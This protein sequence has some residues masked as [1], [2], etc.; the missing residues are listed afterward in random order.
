MIIQLSDW[1]E[2]IVG[3][4]EIARYEQFLLFPQ[5]FQK[6][7]FVDTLKWVSMEE[8][9]N[10]AIKLTFL[11]PAYILDRPYSYRLSHLQCF[12]Y[13]QIAWFKSKYIL[14]PHCL[15]FASNG[16]FGKAWLLID[17][18]VFNSISVISRRLVHL[19]ILSWSGFNHYSTQY[20]L[21]NHWLLSLITAVEQ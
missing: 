10:L 20:F 9:V 4:G 2:N 1:V 14:R 13:F 18:M 12:S 21:P 11:L 17:C 19:S 8:R 15:P 7:S 5:C 3:K 16:S 6:P